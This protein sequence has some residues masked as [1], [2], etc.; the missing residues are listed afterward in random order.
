[1]LAEMATAQADDQNATPALTPRPVASSV[2]EL[3]AGA[4]DREPFFNSDSKSGSSFERVHI[5]GEPHIVKYVHVDDDWT[6]RMSGDIGC[7]PAQ[8]WE[9]GLMDALP[10]RIDHAV[11][12]VATGLGR[13]GWGAALLMRDVSDAMVPEGDAPLTPDDHAQIVDDIAA[14]SA[15][16]WGWRDDIGLVPMGNRY[17]WFNPG[18]LEVER[19]KG[20]PV[21]V[22]K[23]AEEGW[24]RLEAR[25]PRAVV[26][27]VDALRHDLDPLVHALDELPRT[28]VHGDWKLGNVGLGAD[29]R[30]VL[31][32]WAYPGEAPCCYE[33][34]W[35]LAVNR[36]RI[37]ESKEAV[38]DRFRR[39]LEAHGVDTKGWFER[40]LALC[41]I[42]GL[43]IFGW[44]KAYG[45]DDEL[46]WWCDR[47]REGAALL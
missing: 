45:D 16:L 10:D 23:I 12:G 24:E 31:I 2:D 29:G 46:G 27:V 7:H 37:P 14:M 22:P 47:A 1:M 18:C 36:A 41:L 25:A 5:D 19:L 32:D 17:S 44:E 35:H 6:M 13:H 28:F 40:Q 4:T 8:V 3:L 15:R 43:L 39:A 9:A 33:L 30:T 21:P 26:D 34:T 38:I 42:G 11:V 20:W